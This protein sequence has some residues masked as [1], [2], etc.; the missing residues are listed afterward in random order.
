MVDYEYYK[1]VYG[2][3]RVEES[4][5][6]AKL[7]FTA[8]ILVEHYTFGR[9]NL[10]EDEGLLERVKLTICK[11]IDEDVDIRQG[12]N[13]K[14]KT[15]GKRSLTYVDPVDPKERRYEIIHINLSHT[16][17]MDRWV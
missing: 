16:G 13:I 9:V 10:I 7:A 15:Q 11:L 5:E 3:D 12:G 8:Y 17:L 1:E 2:G 14:S 6:F 4:T